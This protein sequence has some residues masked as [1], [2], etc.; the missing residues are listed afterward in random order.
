MMDTQSQNPMIPEGYEDLLESTALAHVASIGPQGK[1]QN[2]PVWFG[3]DG[4]HIKF[5]QTKARQKYRN[6]GRAPRIA[7]SIVDP[8][9]P[10][11]YLEIRGEVVRI[12]D[13]PDLDFINSMAKKYLDMDKYP[14]HQPADERVVIFT[15]P[16]HTTQMG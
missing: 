11:R 5:S 12:E 1:P 6:V 10:Y 15:R 13:D 2:N 3:W 16:E 9:N 8:E 7:F 4:E 14:Y